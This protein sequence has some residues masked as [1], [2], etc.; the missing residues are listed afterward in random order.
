[1]IIPVIIFFTLF[2]YYPL[3][4]GFIISLQ[5]FKLIGSAS[6]IG[7]DNYKKVLSDPVFW[8]AM[9]NTL[10]IGG[11][12]LII[13]FVF[14]IIIAISLNEVINTVF[15][16]AAQMILYLP[17][18]FS[19]VIIG[20]IWIYL[21]SPGDGLVNEIIKLFGG[22]SISFMT[23]SWMAQ[24]IMIMSAIWKDMGF[25]CILYLAAIVGINPELYEAAKIDGANRLQQIWRITIPQLIPTMKTVFILNI[26]GALK[27]FD[28]IFIMRNS[29]IASKVD[30]LLLYT[31]EKGIEQFNMGIAS[32]ASFILILATLILTLI[33]RRILNYGRE[34]V[35]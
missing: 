18:L 29:A 10:I 24:P 31:Y 11:G 8:R 26:M 33:A 7:L 35:M 23:T 21:L 25:L 9:K 17:H 22:K 20:G 30:V 13:G 1:M 28:Q 14:P 16:K 3:V 27:I 2:A 5:D 12:V 6:F 19:W 4:R 15:K 32:A 34:D